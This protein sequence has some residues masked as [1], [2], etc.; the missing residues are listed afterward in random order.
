MISKEQ[1]DRRFLWPGAIIQYTVGMR[2]SSLLSLPSLMLKCD[3][4]A[5]YVFFRSPMPRRWVLSFSNPLW[6]YLT[7]HIRILYIFLE[8]HIRQGDNFSLSVPFDS[9]SRAKTWGVYSLMTLVHST[10]FWLFVSCSIDHVP[11]VRPLALIGFND[12]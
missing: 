4:L 7:C 6:W 3:S 11:W 10:C 1:H 12:I 5:M 8:Q 9:M 2:R